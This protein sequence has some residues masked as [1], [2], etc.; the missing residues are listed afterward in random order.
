MQ[1]VSFTNIFT[2]NENMT[3]NTD[4]IA[5][6]STR[7][8]VDQIP[9]IHLWKK[10]GKKFKLIFECKRNILGYYNVYIWDAQ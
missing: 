4:F 1:Y 2:V 3:I 6:C 10:Y 7:S 8:A 9:H 5:F